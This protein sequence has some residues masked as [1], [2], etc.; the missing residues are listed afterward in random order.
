MPGISL[1]ITH[2]KPKHKTYGYIQ[3]YGSN[4]NA[5]NLIEEI[6]PLTYRHTFD[7]YSDSKTTE[8]AVDTKLTEL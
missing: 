5:K 6:T 2:S 1:T 8:T 7:K 4:V 3:I